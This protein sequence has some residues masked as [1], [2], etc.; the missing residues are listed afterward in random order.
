MDT[1]NRRKSKQWNNF[2]QTL[3][4]EIFKDWVQVDVEPCFSSDMLI[5]MESTFD[6]DN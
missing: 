5:T 3:P 1:L 2:A 6:D 4:T